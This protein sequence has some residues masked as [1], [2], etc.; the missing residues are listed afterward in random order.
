MKNLTLLALGAL[1]FA[2]CDKKEALVNNKPETEV[3]LDLSD[4]SGY[5]FN[6]HSRTSIDNKITLGRVLFYD[7]QLS[8]NNAVSCASCHKQEFAFSDNVAFSRGF[9]GRLTGRNSM[10]IQRFSN[11]GLLSVGGVTKVNAGSLFWDGRVQDLN[12]MVLMPVANHVEMGIENIAE[13]SQKLS[14]LPYYPGLVRDAYGD[15]IITADRISEALVWFL[16]SIRSDSSRFDKHNKRKSVDDFTAQELWG[17]QLFV[18]KY[19]CINCHMPFQPYTGMEG[20]SDIGL[21]LEPKDKG[22]GAIFGPQWNGSFRIP[23]LHNVAI[24][25]PYMHDGRFKTLDE[26]LEHYSKGVQDSKN[27]DERLKDMYGKPMRMNISKDEKAALIAFLNTMTDPVMRTKS[28][29]SNPFRTR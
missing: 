26:V 25:A 8:L 19:N 16:V 4:T 3:Y 24:T 21:D 29:Y 7:G 1:L 23:D 17:E 22:Q 9:E 20:G 10:P 18:T 11:S 6:K 14:R 13:L 5:Y 15:S 27:L 2:S 28:V 12:E